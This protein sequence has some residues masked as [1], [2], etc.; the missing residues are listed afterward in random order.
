[1]RIGRNANTG[2]RAGVDILRGRAKNPMTPGNRSVYHR[3]LGH[4]S[5]RVLVSIGSSRY[6]R[7]PG[8]ARG[9]QGHRRL[10]TGVSSSRRSGE[11]SEGG[12]E[13]DG[14]AG[15]QRIAEG[16]VDSPRNGAL[17][18]S[19][20]HDRSRRGADRDRSGARNVGIC[21]GG[22]S[23]GQVTVVEIKRP[24]VVIFICRTGSGG[25]SHINIRTVMRVKIN[26][27]AEKGCGG[28]VIAGV[29]T[30]LETVRQPIVV[31]PCIPGSSIEGVRRV[32]R[33]YRYNRTVEVDADMIIVGVTLIAVQPG[34]ELDAEA[35]GDSLETYTFTLG[36]GGTGVR[37]DTKD[38]TVGATPSRVAEVKRKEG[39]E[40]TLI[41]ERGFWFPPGGTIEISRRVCNSDRWVASADPYRVAVQLPI[42]NVRRGKARVNGGDC[43]GRGPGQAH[44]GE[45]NHQAQQ[46]YACRHEQLFQPGSFTF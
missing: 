5:G 34:V 11:G 45:D 24:Y 16:V 38:Q 46:Q 41:D 36:S 14:V 26:G 39:A 9:G 37:L 7:N 42:I 10:P 1:M 28:A 12:G 27:A 21:S 43:D 30:D 19:V 44:L 35:V 8:R 17:G 29:H 20:G 33:L 15:A 22:Y 40:R 31:N 25:K 3:L 23:A 13:I 2:V 4:R 18:R 6:R 32:G